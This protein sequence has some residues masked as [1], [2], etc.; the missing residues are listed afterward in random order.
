[1]QALALA[2]QR[3]RRRLGRG[4]FPSASPLRRAIALLNTY[5]FSTQC[6]LP[7]ECVRNLA[8]LH[9]PFCRGE[10]LEPLGRPEESSSVPCP[11]WRKPEERWASVLD[12]GGFLQSWVSVEG[13]LLPNPQEGEEHPAGEPS[14][15]PCTTSGQHSLT[16]LLRSEFN[17]YKIRCPR[18]YSRLS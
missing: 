2:Q 7:T 3:A 11:T 16:G 8:A 12:S 10:V 13:G 18:A 1:M 15:S 17:V 14:R 6:C 9:L 4:W 5:S